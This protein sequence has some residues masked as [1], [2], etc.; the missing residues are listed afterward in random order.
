MK[1]KGTNI[2]KSLAVASALSFGALQADAIILDFAAQGDSAIS[3]D[4]SGDFSFVDDTVSGYDFEVTG[5]TGL[6]TAIGTFGNIQ[7]TFTI[8]TVV[9]NSAPVTGSGTLSIDDGVA[10]LTATVEFVD[11]SQMGALGGLNTMAT[12]NLSS[13]S[14]VGGNSDLLALVSASG[15]GIATVTYQFTAPTT[16]ASL[17]VTDTETSYSGSITAPVGVPDG[18][19]T[20]ML[21]GLALVGLNSLRKRINA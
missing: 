4:G 9:G 8:G 21:L 11:I 16:L 13:I 5:S 2:V 3:F 17:K 6:G 20:I 18:G 19:S 15:E 7:G 12:V 14:Y 10:V 1:I